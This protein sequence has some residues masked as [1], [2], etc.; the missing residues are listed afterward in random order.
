M[1]PTHARQKAQNYGDSMTLFLALSRVIDT[2]TTWIG[3]FTMWLILATTL[4]SAGNAIVR[5]LFGIG[6]NSLL[7]IQWYIFAAVFLL[8]AGYG[9]LRNSHVRID[10]IASKLSA[11]TRNWIDV[12]GILIVLFPFCALMIILSWPLFTQAYY[13][14]E[15][16]S[17]A[18]GLI[19]WPVYALVP[20]GFALLLLQAVS[21]LIKRIAF[22]FG[23]GPDVI[24]HENS[25]SD[26]Q[27]HLEEL[28][29]LAARKLA[30]DN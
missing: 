3:K 16:S 2:I 18:G 24:S 22:L 1:D 15:M 17:N 20:A 23:Q 29:A 12:V 13:S 6:S 19:R 26:E 30:G 28:E 11:R 21:E 5:K 27:K 25:K 9:F 7:E 8:G 4:I 14:G 10:F